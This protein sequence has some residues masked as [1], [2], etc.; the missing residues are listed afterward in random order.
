M[1]MSKFCDD[2]YVK[3]GPATQGE[4]KAELSAL[5][6][7]ALA[8]GQSEIVQRINKVNK[9]T[10]EVITDIKMALDEQELP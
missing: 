1:A 4:L 5:K 9:V 3:S 8:S 2:P 10:E 6:Q 7:E